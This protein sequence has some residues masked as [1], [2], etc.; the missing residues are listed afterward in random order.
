MKN[1][2]VNGPE[3][4]LNRE[5]SWLSFNERVLKESDNSIHPLMERLRFLV[6]SIKN[7]DEFMSVRVAGIKAQVAAGVLATTADGL[8]PAQLLEKVCL[9]VEDLRKAQLRQWKTL[10]RLLGKEGYSVVSADTLSSEDAAF[11]ERRFLE[12]FYPVLTPIAIGPTHPFPFILSGGM[13]LALRLRQ[14][15]GRETLDA[16]IL[17]PSQAGRFICLPGNKRRHVPL[18]EVILRHVDRLFPGFEC[19]GAGM[20]RILR[21]AELELDDDAED[22]FQTFENAIRRRKR[23]S[24]VRLFVG[25]GMPKGL[26]DTLMDALLVQAE[27]VVLETGLMNLADLAQMISVAPPE[28]LFPPHE[29]RYPERIR[30]VGGDCFAAIRQKDMVI[31][32]PYESFDVVVQFLK[33]AARDPDVVAIKQT[34]YRTSKDSSIVKALMEAAE[35][36]KSV[37]AMVELKARFDE[38]ANLRWA[39]DLERA[40]A[41][42]VFGFMEL[43]THAKVSLVVRRESHGMR[44]Y[45]HFGTGNYHSQTARLYTD[46]SFFTCDPA[47]CRDAAHIFNYMTASARPHHLEKLVIAPTLL[48]DEL[49]DLI[50]EEAR[51]ARHGRPGQV[52]AKMNSLVDPEIIDALYKASSAGVQI[53]LVVRGICCLRPGVPDL[54]ENIRVKSIVG[55]F[56]EHSRI[57]CFGAGHGL[58]HEKAKVFISSADW[59]P[60]NLN[61]RIETMV[62]LENATVKRQVLEQIMVANLKDDLQSWELLPD[63]AYK[64]VK[65]GKNPFCANTYFMNN[66]SL[67]G[68]GNA[69]LSGLQPPKLV[70][71][72]DKGKK[73]KGKKK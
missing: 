55:R 40:G 58:P 25:D 52:W 7:L 2:T 6:I 48:R 43:K 53:D 19:R 66:P 44:S 49:L 64:R 59:M 61:R 32:H 39:R 68:R 27:D 33:Q 28:M 42:V 31:H 56:L 69:L 46:I 15:R 36:G 23:G 45:A 62:P 71:R 41:Q 34:L 70:L 4:F 72:L 8:A 73:I 3:R 18:E 65:P 50:G 57:M 5:M 20:F 38:E 51:H 35:A 1:D 21:D 29:I 30:E 11:V 14:L 10:E 22:L 24:V 54:S 47:L 37:T 12:D 13:G 17:L 67:S 9:Q 26:R 63:G 60:R 16:V